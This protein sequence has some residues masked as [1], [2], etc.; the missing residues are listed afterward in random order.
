MRI[1]TISSSFA[2]V[3]ARVIKA[4]AVAGN[5][6]R[7]FLHLTRTRDLRTSEVLGYWQEPCQQSR[8]TYMS[9]PLGHPHIGSPGLGL[10]P[11]LLRLLG[12]KQLAVCP[13]PSRLVFD[14]FSR[15]G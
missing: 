14:Q 8:F 2:S 10:K 5:A 12:M 1:S 9:G 4:V 7:T 15:R 11:E 6:V 13:A 3:V